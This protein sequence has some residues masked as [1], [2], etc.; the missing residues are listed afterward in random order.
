M[1]IADMFCTLTEAARCLRVERHTVW[2]WIR[3]GKMPAQKVGGVVF[4]ERE[5][6]DSM[7]PASQSEPS[8]NEQ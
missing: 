6:I 2:R 8:S 5:L 4:I 1:Q 3:A 7:R